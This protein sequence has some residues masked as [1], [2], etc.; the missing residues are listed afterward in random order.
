V[1]DLQVA[2]QRASSR[3]LKQVALV[4]VRQR[5]ERPITLQW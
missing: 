5:K 4:V 3:G 1:R 2:V